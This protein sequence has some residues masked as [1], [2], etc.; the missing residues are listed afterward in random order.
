V[1]GGCKCR[2]EV[3]CTVEVGRRRL[4]WWEV[5]LLDPEQRGDGA[6]HMPA[7]QHALPKARAVAGPRI[8]DAGRTAVA[9]ASR[10]AALSRW[11]A[12]EAVPVRAAD[13]DIGTQRRSQG[14]GEIWLPC[15]AGNAFTDSHSAR[16][17]VAD[18]ERRYSVACQASGSSTIARL[19]GAGPKSLN[20][21]G[22]GGTDGISKLRV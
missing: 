4:A 11:S 21:G 17:A 19:P 8:G 15:F 7:R 5:R 6:F 3:L 2:A 13:V 22:G 16:H 20:R 14:S 10:E 12:C 9:G 1:A 18:S